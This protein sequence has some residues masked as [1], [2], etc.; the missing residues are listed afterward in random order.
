MYN[1]LCCLIICVTV[2][3]LAIYLT[4]YVRYMVSHN[5]PLFTWAQC[6]WREE[7]KPVPEATPVPMGFVSTTKEEPPVENKRSDQEELNA[8]LQDTASTISALLRGEVDFDE[9]KN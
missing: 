7:K 6:Y 8:I 9:I 1:V 2:L 5:M 3:A 4:Q